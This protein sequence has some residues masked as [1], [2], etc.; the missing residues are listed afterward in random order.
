S[1]LP[2]VTC[3]FLLFC[4]VFAVGLFPSPYSIFLLSH[5]RTYGGW[6]AGHQIHSRRHEGKRH[7]LIPVFSS[8]TFSIVVPETHHK[9]L[10]C[11][12]SK[13]Q[14]STI[15]QCSVSDLGLYGTV[16]WSLPCCQRIVKYPTMP[17]AFLQGQSA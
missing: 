4:F 1:S 2:D 12:S 3:Y 17:A 7:F 6:H 14:K 10:W 11:D 5:G 8:L 15:L 9:G 13:E 16:M